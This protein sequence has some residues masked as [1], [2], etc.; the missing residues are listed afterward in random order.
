MT[1]TP[2]HIQDLHL[3]IWLSKSLSE[4]LYL[5][6]KFNEEIYLFSKEMR[7]KLQ[8]TNAGEKSEEHQADS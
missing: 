1:D 7:E 4:R 2:Q 5:A 3:Q 8:R 6:L